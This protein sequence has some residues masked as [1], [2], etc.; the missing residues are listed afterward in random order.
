MVLLSILSVRP[1]I[2]A[3]LQHLDR[4]HSRQEQNLSPSEVIIICLLGSLV[5]SALKSME[6]LSSAPAEA[7]ESFALSISSFL[8]WKSRRRR[9]PGVGGGMGRW[10]DISMSN[11]IPFS[12]RFSC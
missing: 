9:L 2:T 11:S 3:H 6:F 5:S 7:L 10:G 4:Q 8:F 12:P 1:R